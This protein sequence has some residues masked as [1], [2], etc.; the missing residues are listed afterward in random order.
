M[1]GFE[2]C[3][4]IAVTVC[5]VLASSQSPILSEFESFHVSDEWILEEVGEIGT[6]L[7]YLSPG[8]ANRTS[9]VIDSADLPHIA[10]QNVE[11][12][13]I[14]YAHRDLTGNWSIETVVS[15]STKG[16]FVSLALDS[17]DRPVLCYFNL[18]IPGLSC[19]F[20]DILGWRYEVVD[21]S[22]YSGAYVS[23]ALDT[24]DRVHLAYEGNDNDLKYAWWDGS[25]WNTTV[26]RTRA[27]G[28]VIWV[29]MDLDSGDSPHIAVTSFL[30]E[31]G[32][33]YYKW[34]QTRWDK[35]AVDPS[36]RPGAIFS[37]AVDA[38]DL[39]HLVY[40]DTW[41]QIPRYAYNDGTSWQFRHIGFEAKS[42]VG[43]FTLDSNESPH[44]AYEDYDNWD[45][46]YSFLDRGSWKKEI[47]DSEGLVGF[48]PSI[49]LDS[50]DNPSISYLDL[51]DWVLMYA[52]KK[53]EID[54]NIDIDPDT[55]NLNSRGKWITC[56]IELPL[57]YGPRDINASTI[58]LNDALM[59]ELDPKYGFVESED[60][61]IVDHDGDGIL[62]RMVKFDRS[63]VQEL[64]SP[65]ESVSLTIT[66]RLFDGTKF[67][68]TDEI[69]VVDPPQLFSWKYREENPGISREVDFLFPEA[70]YESTPFFHLN[71][72]C[73]R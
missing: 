39:P 60:S 48:E 56:Y 36:T 19:A 1:I 32:L 43:S 59:P 40:G 34:N 69:R 17:N 12:G 53:K 13:E 58:L 47:V 31:R 6:K 67:E 5:I 23:L 29:S 4:H 25:S 22:R 16:S 42:L 68:G 14:N 44:V 10:F 26:L 49:A 41:E 28:S 33:W 57:R 51:T 52:T 55:L 2:V 50:N 62:E 37:M 72:L 38:S 24:Q 21:A 27:E 71:P 11:T 45:L 15:A 73:L 66:G 70:L 61:Y 7:G 30:P 64:L 20:W 65:G 35:E 46:R 8:T 54:A 63:E 9:I 3:R 18:T